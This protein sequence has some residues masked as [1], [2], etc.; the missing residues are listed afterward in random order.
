MSCVS[1]SSAPFSQSSRGGHMAKCFWQQIRNFTLSLVS[2]LCFVLACPHESFGS[3]PH[4]LLTAVAAPSYS[5]ATGFFEPPEPAI[6]RTECACYPAPGCCRR[7][8]RCALCPAIRHIGTLHQG[9]EH[10]PYLQYEPTHKFWKAGIELIQ[11]H[12]L[13]CCSICVE[14]HQVRTQTPRPCRVPAPALHG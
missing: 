14:P 12:A 13:T 10:K 4:K 11:V 8:L 9:K 2:T 6:P 3:S 7:L 5:A 1:A